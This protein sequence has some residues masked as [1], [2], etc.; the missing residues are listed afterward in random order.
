MEGGQ[1]PPFR[2]YLN[3]LEP[4]QS[5]RFERQAVCQKAIVSLLQYV[6]KPCVLV[7]EGS[8]C[9]IA[10][11]AA[12]VVP[13]LVAGI[14]AVSPSG[15]PFGTA[16]GIKTNGEPAYN[17]KYE[18]S[19]SLRIYGLTD[20]PITFDPP[21]EPPRNI[22]EGLCYD[23]GS[24][25][26]DRYLGDNEPNIGPM[27][28][29]E[30]RTF[31][32]RRNPS[33]KRFWWAQKKRSFSNPDGIRQLENIKKVHQLVLTGSSSENSVYDHATVLFMKQAGCDKL[34]WRRL[35]DFGLSGN[36]RLMFLETNSDQIAHMITTWINKTVTTSL[37]RPSAIAVESEAPQPSAIAVGP[38]AP[39]PSIV[40]ESEASQ[41]SATVV[42]PE[43]QPALPSPVTPSVE[44]ADCKEADC[45]VVE[46]LD[47]PM[48]EP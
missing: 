45:I 38:E 22:L 32:E 25:F 42:E 44:K 21:L 29:L 46:P 48:D 19:K 13:D 14:V 10:W 30:R 39:R 24:S 8:G 11:L 41:P 20:I 47:E 18:L 1:E 31:I 5:T 3:M 7:G 15:P 43:A 36:S 17:N 26:S 28:Y 9:Q 40:K 27:L 35:G 23:S 16:N 34:T 2:N 37:R 12:D 33:T 6:N 4:L